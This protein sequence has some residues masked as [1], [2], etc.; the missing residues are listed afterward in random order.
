MRTG[1][2]TSLALAGKQP[3]CVDCGVSE[4]RILMAEKVQS[5]SDI[6]LNALDMG[7]IFPELGYNHHSRVLVA[8]N[9]HRKQLLNIGSDFGYSRLLPHRLDHPIEQ[10]QVRL[11]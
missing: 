1:F 7:Y 8:P 3:D 6:S 9:P 2:E 10:L 4:F 5:G 11:N